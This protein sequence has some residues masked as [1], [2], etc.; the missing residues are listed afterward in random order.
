MPYLIGE[1]AEGLLK[2]SLLPEVFRLE[3]GEE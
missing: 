3:T 1:V 2:N